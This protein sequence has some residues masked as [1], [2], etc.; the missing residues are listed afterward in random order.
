MECVVI[1]LENTEH[2]YKPVEKPSKNRVSGAA[3][4][5]KSPV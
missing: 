5:Q 4:A 1:I 3:T 2:S